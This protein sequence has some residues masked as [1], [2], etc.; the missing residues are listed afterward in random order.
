PI[1]NF[2]EEKTILAFSFSTQKS[3]NTQASIS[4]GTENKT[5]TTEDT[6]MTDDTTFNIEI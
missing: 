3:N 4:K 2:L 6:N 1:S 5:L